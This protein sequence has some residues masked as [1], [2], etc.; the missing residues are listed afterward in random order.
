MVTVNGESQ[1]IEG[2]NLRR[3]LEDAGYDLSR[4]VVERNLEIIPRDELGIITIREGDTIEV[5]RFVGGG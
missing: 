4:V 3:Y 5:L 2:L 1:D